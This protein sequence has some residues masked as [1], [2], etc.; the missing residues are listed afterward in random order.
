[1][2]IKGAKGIVINSRKVCSYLTVILKKANGPRKVTKREKPAPF[3]GNSYNKIGKWQDVCCGEYWDMSRNI[4]K[5][6]TTTTTTKE[7]ELKS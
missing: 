2:L 3:L 6:I 1:M 7:A 4:N 5:A